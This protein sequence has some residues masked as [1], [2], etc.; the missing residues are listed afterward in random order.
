MARRTR[1]RS[2]FRGARKSTMPDPTP[3]VNVTLVL[4]I[5][6]MVFVMLLHRALVG[7]T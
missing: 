7:A 4:M 6:L 2:R 3:I 1:R 5:L